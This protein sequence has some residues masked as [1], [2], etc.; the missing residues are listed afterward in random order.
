[1][2]LNPAVLGLVRGIVFAVLLAILTVL[3]NAA[4]LH[5]IVPEAF[6]GLI[7]S[8][9]LAL[10]HWLESRGQGALFGAVNRRT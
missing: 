8:G 1:M 3:G 5:G 7:A 2:N 9:A 6:E 10:E 4:N